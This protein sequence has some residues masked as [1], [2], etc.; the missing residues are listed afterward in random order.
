MTG[1]ALV[2]FSERQFSFHLQQ[3]VEERE[4]TPLVVMH[5]GAAR[6]LLAAAPV[7]TLLLEGVLVLAPGHPDCRAAITRGFRVE[8]GVPQHHRAGLAI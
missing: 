8:R 7:P 6:G 5:R 2:I 4:F 1:S 3:E